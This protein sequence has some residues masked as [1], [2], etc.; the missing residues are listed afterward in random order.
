MATVES[1]NWL[2]C[3]AELLTF[4]AF[5]WHM[6]SP[7]VGDPTELVDFLRHCLLE[8]EHGIVQGEPIERVMLALAGITADEL[9]GGLSGVDFTEPLFFNGICSALRKDAPY[10]LRR[11]TATFFCHLDAQFFDTKKTFGKDQATKLVPRWSIS[12]TSLALSIPQ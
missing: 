5:K 10:P 6:E 7:F 1:D 3:P 4:G 9:G 2:W 12:P 8:Q 11:A